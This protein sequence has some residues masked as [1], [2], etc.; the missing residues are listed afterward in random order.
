MILYMKNKNLKKSKKMVNKERKR[1]LKKTKKIQRI[2]SRKARGIDEEFKIAIRTPL[3]LSPKEKKRE[4][5]NL[6]KEIKR[7]NMDLFHL[8][9]L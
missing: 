7:S 1:L 2:G 8:I 4:L 9:V 3:P 6:A 5:I